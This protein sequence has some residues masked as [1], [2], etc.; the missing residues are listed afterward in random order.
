MKKPK[1]SDKAVICQVCRYFIPKGRKIEGYCL[2]DRKETK[3]TDGCKKFESRG[4][5]G[6]M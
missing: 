2:K 4:K 3:I 1:V 6:K 5:N